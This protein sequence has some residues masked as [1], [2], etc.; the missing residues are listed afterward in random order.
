MHKNYLSLKKFELIIKE[1]IT[2][3]MN[4]NNEKNQ[5]KQN[6]KKT[7]YFDEN[8]MIHDFSPEKNIQVIKPIPVELSFK[9]SNDNFLLNKKRERSKGL[10]EYN[11]LYKNNGGNVFTSVFQS[12][13]NYNDKKVE[14]QLFPFINSNVINLNECIFNSINPK[15]KNKNKK[16]YKPRPNQIKINVIIN[17][18]ITTD[19]SVLKEEKE[20]NKKYFWDQKE[21]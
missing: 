4:Q 19:S 9:Q 17:N 11:N 10:F 5:K 1:D 8:K 20:Y 16:L 12:F 2:D 6:Q 18:Y 3:R 7:K 15:N 14:N 13:N 21:R